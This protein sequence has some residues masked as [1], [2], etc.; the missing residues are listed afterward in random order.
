MWVSMVTGPDLP[1]GAV[2]LFDPC[3]LAAASGYQF[4]RFRCNTRGDLTYSPP[5]PLFFFV[6]F[7]GAA[8]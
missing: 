4:Q 8:A 1:I 2:F 3:S 6:F 5:G 7:P